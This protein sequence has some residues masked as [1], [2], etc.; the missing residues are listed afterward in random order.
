MIWPSIGVLFAIDK[1]GETDDERMFYGTQARRIFMR[2]F[3]PR[4]IGGAYLWHGD[5]Q[6]RGPD[7][8]RRFCIAVSLQDGTKLGKVQ[9]FF[10]HESD[11]GLAPFTQR[12]C[13][14]PVDVDFST[15]APRP[16]RREPLPLWLGL[17]SSG[18]AVLPVAD[19]E[20]ESLCDEFG[21]SFRVGK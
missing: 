12:F 17:D 3:N 6:T 5:A 10:A 11:R 4:A 2:H 9:E 19:A 13:M 8:E 1:L 21:W 14:H 20:D 16:I 18:I 7:G 15:G